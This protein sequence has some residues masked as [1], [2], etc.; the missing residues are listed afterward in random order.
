MRVVG[1]GRAGLWGRPVPECTPHRRTTTR[2]PLHLAPPP[3]LRFIHATSRVSS[4]AKSGTDCCLS[5]T[6]L[7]LPALPAGCQLASWA[8]TRGVRVASGRQRQPSVLCQREPAGSLQ[9]G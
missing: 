6:A 3:S 2:V 5:S 1:S 7:L 4:P 8:A 9:W